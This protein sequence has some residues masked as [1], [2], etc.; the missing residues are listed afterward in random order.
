MEDMGYFFKWFIRISLSKCNSLMCKI[1]D[2]RD[3]KVFISR[4]YKHRKIDLK[5]PQKLNEKILWLEYNTDS[6]LR[7][8]LTDKYEV[9]QYV[10][11]KGYENTL[12]P[13]YG[14]YD[15][16]EE[17]KFEKIPEQF[18]LKATHGCDMNYICRSKAEMN[19]HKLHRLVKFWM[20]TNIAYISLEMHYLPIK[21]RLLCEKFMDSGREN[22]TDY[23]FHCSD[24]IPRF[25]LVCS[26]GSGRRYRDV[27]DLEWNHLNVVEGALQNPDKPQKPDCF[28]E[29][30]EIAARLAEGI[31]FVRVDLYTLQDKVYF[32]EMTFTPATGILFHF[33]EDFLLEQGKYCT[34]E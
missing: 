3:L 34:I 18:V 20:K 9:R 16:F 22:I 17:I 6:Q 27:F 14:I 7:S 32:G 23:K 13:I 11:N 24:G 31:Q 33:T 26:Y 4:C 1:V 10:A 29:M 12:I 15:S 8:R 28:Q 21:P 25:V 19:I 2:V 5:H 30:C